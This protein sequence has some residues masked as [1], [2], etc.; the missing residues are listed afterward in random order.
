MLFIDLVRSTGCAGRV[1]Q[2]AMTKEDCGGKYRSF[3]LRNLLNL[4]G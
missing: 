2:C 3:L 4:I 1:T